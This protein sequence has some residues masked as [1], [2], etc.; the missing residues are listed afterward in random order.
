[1]SYDSTLSYADI[2]RLD[3]VCVTNILYWI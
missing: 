2:A 1:M 3:V